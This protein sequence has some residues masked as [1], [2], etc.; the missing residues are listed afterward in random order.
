MQETITNFRTLNYLGS[1]LRLLDFIEEQV[2]KVSPKGSA[3]CDL[4]AGSGCVSYRLSQ[5][6]AVYTCDIQH[7]SKV[8]CNAMLQHHTITPSIVLD[9]INNIEHS[10]ITGLKEAFAPLIQLE[11]KAIEG[12]QLEILTQI[13]ENGSVEVFRIENTESL[14]SSAQLYSLMSIL[15]CQLE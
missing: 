1:K 3:I 2:E 13:I 8:I 5:K 9:L 12:R 11:T 10:E 15:L 6:Y 4:F 14:L 7:Y